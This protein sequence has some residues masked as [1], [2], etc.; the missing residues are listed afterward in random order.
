MWPDCD[1]ALE[2]G[3]E[4]DKQTGEERGGSNVN[5][6]SERASVF[7]NIKPILVTTIYTV[8]IYFVLIWRQLN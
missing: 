4:L 3:E 7:A 6:S 2:D 8:Q 5:Q 1:L